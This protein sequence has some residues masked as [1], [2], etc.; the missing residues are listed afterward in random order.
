MA[1]PEGST[2]FGRVRRLT[3]SDAFESAIAT[4]LV[5]NAGALLLESFADVSEYDQW[6]WIF[7]IGSQ[8]VF[9]VEILLRILG[10]GPRFQD[11]F[12]DGWNVF[13]FAVVALSLV[14]VVGP[15]SFLARMVRLVRVLRVLRLVSLFARRSKRGAS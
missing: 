3:E 12:K 6:L 8:V 13:D 14:P 2:F 10:Y 11:F 15:L 1:E 5:L 4:L 9:V 7:F